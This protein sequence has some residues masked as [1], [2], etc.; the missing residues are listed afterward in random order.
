MLELIG[1]E[2]ASRGGHPQAR[3]SVSGALA[4]ESEKAPEIMARHIPALRCT[5]RNAAYRKGQG[6]TLH[7]KLRFY[8]ELREEAVMDRNDVIESMVLPAVAAGSL[9]FI[10][11]VA[12]RP[13]IF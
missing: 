2:E 5:G 10:F 6:R 11:F 1:Q 9:L 13:F 4:E 7:T 8:G 12:L 3:G